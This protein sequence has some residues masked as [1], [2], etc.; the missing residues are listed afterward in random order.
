MHFRTEKEYNKGVRYRQIATKKGVF[1]LQRISIGSVFAYFGRCGKT[2][3]LFLLRMLGLL[4]W[5]ILM[6]LTELF[7]ILVRGAAH[8][9]DAAAGF[10][11]ARR[12]NAA[13]AVRAYRKPSGS[14]LLSVLRMLREIVF[15]R[16]G[17]LL[18]F[19]RFAVPVTSCL[20]L[21]AVVRQFQNRQYGIA[22]AV[23]GKPLGMIAEESDY[24]TAEEIVRERLSGSESG[25]DVS[26]SRSFQIQEYDGETEIMTAAVLADKMLEQA[27]IA[28][29]DAYGVYV[30]GNF[31][32][33]VT[34]THPVKAALTRLLSAVS[35]Q[36]GGDV[37]DVSFA[38]SVTYEKGMYPEDS[39]IP[40]QKLANRLTAAEH[41]TRTYTAGKTDTIYSVAARFSTTPAELRRL[42]P[43][44]PDV[45]PP[46]QRVKV[47]YVKRYLPVITT[48]KTFVL[49]FQDYNTVRTETTELP[50]G[51]EERV[52]RGIKGEKQS[53]VLITY[54]DGAETTR[55]ELASMQTVYPRDEE[56]A[57]GIFEAKPYSTE[58][59]IDGN[60]KYFWPVDGGKVT[61]WFGGEREHGG[62]DIG[63]AEYS[64]IYAA[65]AGTVLYAGWEPG[66]GNFVILE[67]EDGYY[68]VY[69][70]CVE[71]LSQPEMKVKR[72]DVIALV[73]NTGDSTGAHL[74]FEVRD[75]T[76]E[77]VNPA[78][79]LHVNAD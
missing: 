23:G 12:Q 64:E 30:N 49:S 75:P 21:F 36:Y 19:L 59:V 17:M 45:M 7:G 3:L 58:T 31:E 11:R 20:I 33:A 53:Q 68:T 71:L 79:F 47:P 26:F 28:L 15:G 6:G 50:K 25:R 67:H 48:R 14:R 39:L 74:H 27:D 60:G 10:L 16:N 52:Q 8:L 37:E 66:Y 13:L 78:A 77:R 38:D 73:G 42:N 56:I 35:D 63:A 1:F 41:G 46:A 70:H 69:G 55:R 34:D 62:I 57:V 40:A 2:V 18:S 32:G 24:F 4:L 22:V 5:G 9:A 65:D 76:G 29:T 51:Q 43:K 44:L 61:D 72:G 54:T